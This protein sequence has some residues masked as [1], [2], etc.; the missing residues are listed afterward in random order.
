MVKNVVDMEEVRMVTKPRF[1]N[2]V[3]LWLTN[4]GC[5]PWFRYGNI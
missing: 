5:Q 4:H 2:M 1:T 3:R